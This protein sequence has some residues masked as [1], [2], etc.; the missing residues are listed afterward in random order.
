MRRDR[1]RREDRLSAVT[2]TVIRDD[3][4]RPARR[5]P[6]TQVDV[7][8]VFGTQEETLVLQT[9]QPSA[10]AWVPWLDGERQW[11]GKRDVAAAAWL[12]RQAQAERSG[13]VVQG[14]HTLTATERTQGRWVCW[15]RRGKV[16]TYRSP[17]GPGATFVHNA[18]IR[19]LATA[20]GTAG[21]HSLVATKLPTFPLDG[22]AMATRAMNLATGT[23]TEETRT[24]EQSQMIDGLVDQLYN[25]WSH[26][27]VGRRATAYYLP[28]LVQ[29]GMTYAVFVGSL[30]ALSPRH[31]DSQSDIDAIKRAL[32]PAWE[33]ERAKL[34]SHWR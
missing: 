6:G 33:A 9:P 28:R 2:A 25:G 5:V 14:V 23:A 10:A 20:M 21:G 31:L 30:V 32:P 13:I 22:W 27:P 26:E 29:S 15:P 18:N 8:V 11:L 4:V 3:D 17:A 7:P 24:G 16:A 34:A 1:L 19:L 12:T